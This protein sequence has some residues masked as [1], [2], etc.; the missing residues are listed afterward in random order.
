M[1]KFLLLG[2]VLNFGCFA[3]SSMNSVDSPEE[4]EHPKMVAFLVDVEKTPIEEEKKFHQ[5]PQIKGDSSPI[6]NKHRH[7]P[8]PRRNPETRVMETS[9]I[10]DYSNNGDNSIADSKDASDLEMDLV[11]AVLDADKENQLTIPSKKDLFSGPKK[12]E[13]LTN[14]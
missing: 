2:V 7:L 12:F 9:M 4:N 11:N 13:K 14:W 8:S 5:A 6:R 3:D 10:V 1:L